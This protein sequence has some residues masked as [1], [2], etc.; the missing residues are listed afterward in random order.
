MSA[1]SKRRAYIRAVTLDR[2]RKRLI[3]VWERRV[4]AA[5]QEHV[6]RPTALTRQKLARARAMKKHRVRLHDLSHRAMKNKRRAYFKAK[7]LAA[8]DRAITWATQQVGTTEATGN[9][10]GAKI[11]SWQRATARGEK[12]LD[13]APYCGI[14]CENA[15]RRA[16]VHT[17]SRW[18]AVAFIEDDARRGGGGFTAW[19]RDPARVKP[20]DLVVMYGRGVH[21]EIVRRIKAGVVYTVGFNTSPGITGSQ[22]NG[23]GVYLRARPMSIVHGFAL[24]D[25]PRS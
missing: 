6:A 20:G 1:A 8:R 23:G 21:V 19:T 25:Y 17:T 5:M 3:A 12:Y 13:R 16:G 18:A 7:T 11:L 9:N 14:G 10:D 15:C 4:V 2:A 24:V 22:S